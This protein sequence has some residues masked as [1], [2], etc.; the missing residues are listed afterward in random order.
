MKNIPPK[1]Y[2]QTGLN[3][4]YT[5]D[6][7]DD[8][9]KL[10]QEHVTWCH[11]KCNESDLEYL[12]ASTVQVNGE[13][14]DGYHTFNELY[15]FRKV[16]NAVMFNEWAREEKYRVHKSRRHYDNELC[17]GGGWFIVLALLPIGQISFHYKEED[18][19][20]FN[21]PEFESAQFEFDGHT[22]QQVL[23]RLI[24]HAMYSRTPDPRFKDNAL[25]FVNDIRNNRFVYSE[26]KNV[27]VAAWDNYTEYTPNEL[28]DYWLVKIKN[29]K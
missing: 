26:I 12:L 25:K 23:K 13:T 11:D 2:L 28:Y 5:I 20:L 4:E 15:N 3:D 16:L 24:T 9:R 8:F 21:I 1:I 7:C 22:S 6:E 29:K 18:W 14:S 10:N 17:F 19:G 27:Y